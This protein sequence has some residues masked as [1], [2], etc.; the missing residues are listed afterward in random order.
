LGAIEREQLLNR[1]TLVDT[2]FVN[3]LEEEEVLVRSVPGID[4]RKISDAQRQI[5]KP[6]SFE[7]DGG[8]GETV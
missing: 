8:E 3:I 7:Q 2:S 1:I 5:P 6:K 4:S